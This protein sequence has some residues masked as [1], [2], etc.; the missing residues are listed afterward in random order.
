MMSSAA[1]EP[2][3]QLWTSRALPPGVFILALAAVID[4]VGVVLAVSGGGLVLLDVLARLLLPFFRVGAG[5]RLTS[6]TRLLGGRPLAQTESPL[7][8]VL[9]SRP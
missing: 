3:V 5:G 2:G 1:A 4:D 6:Q 9:V 8:L 7:G